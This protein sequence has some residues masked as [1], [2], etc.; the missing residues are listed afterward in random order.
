MREARNKIKLIDREIKD[1]RKMILDDHY[2]PDA[3]NDFVAIIA[4]GVIAVVGGIAFAH[5]FTDIDVL[6]ILGKLK[7]MVGPLI[8]KV[9]EIVKSYLG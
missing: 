1:R 8:Q 2:G 4:L 7:S 5:Y 3:S 9:I 6:G